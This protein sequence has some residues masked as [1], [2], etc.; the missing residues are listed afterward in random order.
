MQQADIVFMVDGSGSIGAANFVKLENFVKNIVSKLDVGVNGVHVGLMQ[1]SNYPSKE[2]PL[3][4][5]TSRQDVMT[6]KNIPFGSRL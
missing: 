2:F 6:G 1:F 4:M 5:Y 3:S